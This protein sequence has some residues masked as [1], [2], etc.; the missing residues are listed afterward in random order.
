MLPQDELE[1]SCIVFKIDEVVV[2]DVYV[3]GSLL[4]V[5]SINKGCQPLVGKEVLE[6]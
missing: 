5:P 2:V 1:G 4:Q 3:R 6:T